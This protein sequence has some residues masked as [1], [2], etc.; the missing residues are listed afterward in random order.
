MPLAQR[1]GPALQAAEL[2]DRA[3]IEQ[4]YALYSRLRREAEREEGM[5]YLEAARVLFALDEDDP[6]ADA[7]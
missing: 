2:L 1:Q 6:P 7:E 5:A 4:P 3:A